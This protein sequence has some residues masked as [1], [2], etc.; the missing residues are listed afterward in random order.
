MNDNIALRK[1]GFGGFNKQDVVDYI[2]QMNESN[3]AREIEYKEQIAQ[4]MHDCEDL[5][6]ECKRLSESLEN[7]RQ[8]TEIAEKSVLD[9]N[10]TVSKLEKSLN[11]QLRLNDENA[12]EIT[13]MAK[14]Y[15]IFEEKALKYDELSANLSETLLESRRTADRLINEAT[16]QA[17][18]LKTSAINDANRQLSESKAEAESL[19][20]KTSQ[21]ANEIA[22]QKSELMQRIV[23]E[24][25]RFKTI[26]ISAKVMLS[27]VS[28]KIS[29]ELSTAGAVL[30][31]I[32]QEMSSFIQS[33]TP[34][35]VPQ[36]DREESTLSTYETQDEEIQPKSKEDFFKFKS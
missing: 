27:D 15:K 4:L 7:Q 9:L 18:E 13:L 35:E 11:D 1:S 22:R 14:D 3:H 2:A 30:S 12:Q 23:S 16:A 25:E 6:A 29:Q 34:N 17:E 19:L 31:G 28:N 33:I 24:S 8:Q 36:T 10:A 32:D 5:A 21:I 20:A 26:S